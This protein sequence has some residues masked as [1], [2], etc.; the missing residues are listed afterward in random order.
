MKIQPKKNKGDLLKIQ[1]IQDWLDLSQAKKDE[2]IEYAKY[3]TIIT[4]A[5]FLRFNYQ[6]YKVA[7]VFYCDIHQKDIKDLNHI[8]YKVFAQATLA[9]TAHKIVHKIIRRSAITPINEIDIYKACRESFRGGICQAF[10][11]KYYDM[12]QPENDDYSLTGIDANSLYPSM[13][14]SHE[15]QTAMTIFVDNG[16]L[17]YNVLARPEKLQMY[18]LYG[19]SSFRLSNFFHYGL[20]G[21]KTI[22]TE[23]IFYPLSWDRIQE[24]KDI[25]GQVRYL[26]HLP[27]KYLWLWGF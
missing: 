20:F 8:D 24:L 16:I 3:D 13:M 23:R 4:L 10:T 22:R 17:S 12:D 11:Q 7:R 1:S 6:I 5:A 27:H 9:Q 14:C 15:F 26:H 19:V 18:T 25:Y 21:V 2:I